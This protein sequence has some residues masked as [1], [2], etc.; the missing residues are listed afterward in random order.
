[1]K[2]D[3]S[4]LGYE[5]LSSFANKTKLAYNFKRV[6]NKVLLICQSNPKEFPDLTGLAASSFQI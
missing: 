6:G 2:M 5:Q 3:V 4:S 1:M